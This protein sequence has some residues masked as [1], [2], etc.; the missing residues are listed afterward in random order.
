MAD[1]KVTITEAI[2]LQ[3]NNQ[4][5]TITKTISGINEV[6][7]RLISVLHTTNGTQLYKGAA[8]AGA[9]T[10]ISGNVKYIRITNLDSTNEV[11]LH[12]EGSSHY[13]QFLLGPGKTYILGQTNG[14]DN[15]S[16]IDSTSGN[17]IT[18]IEGK[19]ASASCVCEVFIASA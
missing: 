9:G 4:G 12:L 11:A 2:K 16:D 7:R 10:F 1:L 6:D 8:A 15:A 13:A 14:F 18:L 17:T 3:N 5:A 19:A